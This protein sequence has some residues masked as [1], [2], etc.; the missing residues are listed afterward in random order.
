SPS[1]ISPCTLHYLPSVPSHGLLHSF[2]TRRSS[3]LKGLRVERRHRLCPAVR[4]FCRA[5][6]GFSGLHRSQHDM[7]PPQGAV[8]K[9]TDSLH[10]SEEHTSEL[11]SRGH[12]VCRLRL[13]K[14]K[15]YWSLTR[16]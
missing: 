15:Y 1:C 9:R 3:D 7:R 8:H 5:V 4:G 13:A 6:R 14:K 11:Q 16:S 2:P 12:L 10:R